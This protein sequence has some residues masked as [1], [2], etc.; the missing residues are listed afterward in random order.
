MPKKTVGYVLIALGVIAAVVSLAADAIGIGT[1]PG[2]NGM[3]LLGIAI[4]VVVALAGAWLAFR[5]AG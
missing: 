5:K 1:E 2:I 4:G 3:Q